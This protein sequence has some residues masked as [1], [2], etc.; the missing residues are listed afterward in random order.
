M[1]IKALALELYR[2]QQKLDMI[3][4][5]IETSSSEEQKKLENEL[6]IAQKE[7]QMLRKMLDGQK[8]SGSFR[9]RF[10]KFGSFT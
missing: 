10:D 3:Q 4:K 7:W 8:E 9:K 2:A 5:K 1:S 6:K